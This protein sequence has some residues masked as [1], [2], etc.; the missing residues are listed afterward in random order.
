M[1]IRPFILIWKEQCLC[2]ASA[3]PCG[4]PWLYCL[5]S[6]ISLV[7]GIY[8]TCIYYNNYI[9]LIINLRCSLVNLLFGFELHKLVNSMFYSCPFHYLAYLNVYNR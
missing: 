2:K 5:T 3:T 6:L 8:D 7:G 1:D 9:K 4:L